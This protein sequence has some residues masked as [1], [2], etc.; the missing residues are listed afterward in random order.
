MAR[1][2]TIDACSVAL[3]NSLLATLRTCDEAILLP[4]SSQ[5]V[6]SGSF[7]NIAFRLCGATTGVN[8]SLFSQ[9]W[10][11]G[12]SL[13]RIRGPDVAKLEA[14]LGD[15][16]R[17]TEA[18]R[19]L[20]QR[21]KSEVADSSLQVGP[22]LECD[23]FER[24]LE[25]STWESGF[26]SPSSF[27]G[28][29]SAQ[30]S[31]APE[32]GSG[33]MR[34]AHKDLF[35][36]C[37]AGAGVAASTFHSRLVAALQK[38]HSLDSALEGEGGQPGARALRRVAMAGARN[39]SRILLEAVD[40]LGLTDVCS[41]GDQA[42][43]NKHRGVVADAETVANTIRKL[44]DVPRSTYQYS[45]CV[46]G[47]QSKGL[48]TLSNQA[49]GVVLFLTENGDAK[50]A[51]K[52]EMWSCVPFTSKRTVAARGMVDK[53]VEVRSKGAAHPDSEWV[54]S[55]FSWNNRKISGEGQPEVEPFGL[56]GA[57]DGEAFVQ[58]FSR[59]L[60]IAN[61]QA[62]RL[63]PELVCSAGVETGKLRAILKAAPV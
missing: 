8:P 54:G 39:R 42:A 55:R 44:D 6:E 45:T 19:A 9:D 58:T 12:V 62:V 46:D 29:F 27:V 7:K 60:G 50:I 31:K 52:N 41:I 14:I 24:D 11:T 20:A 25:R 56:W 37:R 63:R 38:G 30:H 36:V 17:R 49:D 61:Y 26:D 13:V 33:G 34:R 40:V 5:S 15:A 48:L 57:F 2:L 35:L 43:R 21:I 23:E 4:Q 53:I 51:L 3:R 28:V 18:L 59:E 10:F 1:L 16:G 22:Q 47:T 32:G